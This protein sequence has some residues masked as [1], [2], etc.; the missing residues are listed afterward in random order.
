MLKIVLE[1]AAVSYVIIASGLLLGPLMKLNLATTITT[2][3][4]AT[5]TTRCG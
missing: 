4:T 5:T 3:S 1:F 2:T